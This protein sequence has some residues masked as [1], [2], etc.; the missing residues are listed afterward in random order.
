M[1]NTK[2]N[3][4]V[5]EKACR[6]STKEWEKL[7]SEDAQVSTGERDVERERERECTMFTGHASY[8]VRGA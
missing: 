1:L 4:S 7:T 6:R 5:I 3:A 8:C 2:C